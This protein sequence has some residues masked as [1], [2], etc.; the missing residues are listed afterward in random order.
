MQRSD[1]FDSA[2]IQLESQ[3]LVHACMSWQRG[4]SE[5]VVDLILSQDTARKTA[6]SGLAFSAWSR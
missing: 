6:G 1:A 4:G 2:T 3:V 5:V